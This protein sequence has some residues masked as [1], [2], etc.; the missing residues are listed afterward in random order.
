M[1]AAIPAPPTTACSRA[2]RDGKPLC[3]D[4]HARAR[5]DAA[6]PP[7]SRR[8]SSAKSRCPTA[9]ARAGLPA[10]RR[11][12]SRSAATRPTRSPSAAASP[13]TTIRRI[14]RRARRMPPST[15]AIDCSIALDRLGRPR[16]R[17]DDRPAGRDAR[18]ARHLARTPTASTPAARIHLL[19]MLLGTIDTP[20]GFRYKPPYPAP[21]AAGPEA[22]RQGR[23]DADDAARRRAARLSVAARRT[24][25]STPTARR[26][27]IDKAFSWEAP[28]AAHGMMHTRHPQCL[29]RRSLHDRHA[30]HVHGQHGLELVDEHRRDDARMLTDKDARRRLPHPAHH[31]FRRLF[32]ARWSP[33]PIWCCP[34]R[35]ISSATTASRCS[36]G[37]SADADG[38]GRRDPPAGASRPTATC[39]RSRT[40]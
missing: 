2:T 29:A 38:A 31:L 1:I 23:R 32:L 16:A 25:W 11:A 30:V 24:C 36:T 37:R 4:R 3:W 28:L 8:R 19:Q 10:A 17:D 27:R 21:I 6:R 39:G 7:T 35:P 18:D 22:G 15:Q 13:P 33:M 20:G 12:L 5:V 26:V 40:C 34:T 14:A 9:A